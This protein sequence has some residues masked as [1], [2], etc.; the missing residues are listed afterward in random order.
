MKYFLVIDTAQSNESGPGE[1]LEIHIYP[2][3]LKEFTIDQLKEILR[4]KFRSL[5][6][7][8]CLVLEMEKVSSD[9][10]EIQE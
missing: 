5:C 6:H 4:K 10:F 7:G 8:D 3:Q 1:I 2:D 9:I